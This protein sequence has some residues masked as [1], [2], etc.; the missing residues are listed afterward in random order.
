MYPMNMLTYKENTY[1]SYAYDVDRYALK[2]GVVD[3]NENV[4][5]PPLCKYCHVLHFLCTDVW[6]E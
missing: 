6:C 5:P 3:K 1:V 2:N 4:L